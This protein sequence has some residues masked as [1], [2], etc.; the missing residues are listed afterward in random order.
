MKK[1]KISDEDD[2]LDDFEES[3]SNKVRERERYL[4]KLNSH[5]YSEVMLL[6][7]GVKK[8]FKNEIFL[9]IFF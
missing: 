7:M 8:P 5:L 4:I 1:R 3:L 9:I 2:D 6:R